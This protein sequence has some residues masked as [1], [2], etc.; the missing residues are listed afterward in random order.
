M[1]SFIKGVIPNVSYAAKSSK[2]LYM[3]FSSS[4]LFLVAD[5]K[6][7]DILS[8]SPVGMWPASGAVIDANPPSDILS[9]FKDQQEENYSGNLDSSH[10]RELCDITI[11]YLEINS[12]RLSSDKSNL[13]KIEIKTGKETLEFITDYI[14]LALLNEY[15]SMLF[16]L[17]GNKF[18]F[19]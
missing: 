18:L 3:F 5:S 2:I 14:D 19:V 11:S 9:N 15:K 6:V 8:E 1:Q 7:D 10:L 12:I 17:F 4:A 13:I 16:A